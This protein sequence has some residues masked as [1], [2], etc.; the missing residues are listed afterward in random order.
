[1]YRKVPQAA[2]QEKKKNYLLI[3]HTSVNPEGLPA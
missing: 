3:M 1:M 2:V